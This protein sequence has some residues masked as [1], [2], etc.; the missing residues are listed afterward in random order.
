MQ[1]RVL[2]SDPYK[3]L[4]RET[5][6]RASAR[7]ILCSVALYLPKHGD[8]VTDA[9]LTPAISFSNTTCQSGL[10]DNMSFNEASWETRHHAVASVCVLVCVMNVF[11]QLQTINASLIQKKIP[12]GP[13]EHLRQRDERGAVTSLRR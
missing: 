1:R 7:I 3:C 4:R 10:Y 5:G 8:S 9:E 6:S 13:V 2:S 12:S 11:S